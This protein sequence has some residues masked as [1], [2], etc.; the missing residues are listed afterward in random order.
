MKLERAWWKK[1]GQADQQIIIQVDSVGVI[2]TLISQE[3]STMGTHWQGGGDSKRH[4]VIFN[5][6]DI[7]TEAQNGVQ[8]KC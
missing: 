1:K 3:K 6:G 7:N 2:G 4:L 5:N 8:S